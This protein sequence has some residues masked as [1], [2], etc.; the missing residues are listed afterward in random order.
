MLKTCELTDCNLGRWLSYLSPRLREN[1][2][3]IKLHRR[4]IRSTPEYKDNPSMQPEQRLLSCGLVRLTG[5]IDAAR[6]YASVKMLLRPSLT[7]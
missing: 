3:W 1:C 7:D 2:G 5:A 6:Q 4:E